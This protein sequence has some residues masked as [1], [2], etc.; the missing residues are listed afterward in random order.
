MRILLD[1]SPPRDLASL[2]PGHEVTTVRAMGWS[3][4]RNGRL[5]AQ[6]APSFDAFLTADKNLEYQ[7]NLSALPLT[8]VVLRARS[9]R[10]QSLEPLLPDLIKLLDRIAPRTLHRVGV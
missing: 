3:G 6:A 7:Q 5:L 4:F 10:I 2:L 8:V 9:N 1:E